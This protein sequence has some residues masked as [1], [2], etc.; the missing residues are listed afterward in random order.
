[1]LPLRAK[2]QSWLRTGNLSHCIAKDN[3]SC[4]TWKRLWLI[5][6]LF[7]MICSLPLKSLYLPIPLAL[8]LTM[9]QL[10]WQIVNKRD[11]YHFHTELWEAICGCTSLIFFCSKDNT[12]SVYTVSP[13][14]IPEWS[15]MEENCYGPWPT[16]DKKGISHNCWQLL[17]VEIVW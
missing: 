16:C 5:I 7:Q 11:N 2:C 1:M 8:N 13:I 6:W 4:H 15:Y 17:Q 3:F 14:P 9:W 12:T 10:S